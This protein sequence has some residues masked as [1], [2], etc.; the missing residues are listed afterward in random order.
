MENMKIAAI[1]N[2]NGIVSNSNK[3]PIIFE[4]EFCKTPVNT[5]EKYALAS[6]VK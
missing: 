1:I 6:N 5:S 2:I 3:A 4:P